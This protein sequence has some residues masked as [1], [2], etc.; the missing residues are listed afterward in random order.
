MR[1]KN[2]YLLTARDTTY[3]VCASGVHY[4]YTTHTYI[5]TYI[6]TVHRHHTYLQLDCFIRIIDF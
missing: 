3:L 1:Y 6:H 4:T 2:V 5:H